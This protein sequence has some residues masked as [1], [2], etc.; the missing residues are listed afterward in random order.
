M[1]GFVTTYAYKS[2]APPVDR[3]ALLSM[4]E[5]MVSR[6][7]DGEGLWVSDDG[8]VGLAHRRLAIID[9]SYEANQPLTI[10]SGRYRIVY[11]GEIYNFRDLRKDLEARGEIFQTH[12]DTEVLLRLYKVY[13]RDMV[14]KLRGMYAFSIWDETKK[15][16]F[17]A[18]DPFGIKP[19]YY[20][21]D[22][23]TF[24]AASQVKALLKGAKLS[25][26][27]DPAGHVGFFLFG[28]VPEPHTLFSDIHAL[29]AGSTL[30]V[31]GE[32]AH[33]ENKF[34]DLGKILSEAQENAEAFAAPNLREALLDSVRHHLVSDVPVGVFLS[35]GLDSG[36]LAGLASEQKK[37]GLDTLTLG[38]DAFRGTSNDEVPLAEE[39]AK[40]YGT[41]HTT[42]RLARE[43]FQGELQNL[44]AAMDQPTI[45][46]VNTYFVSK[47]AAGT[48]LK[49]AISGLGGDELFAGYDSFRQ[50]PALVSR[51]GLVPGMKVLGRGLRVLTA[52]L[53]RHMTSPKYAGLLEYGTRYEDAY[54]LRRSLFMPWELPDVLDADMVREGWEAL[55]PLT[56]LGETMGKIDGARTKVTALEAAWYMKN[57]LL[58]DADWAGMAHSLEIRT[59]L[60]DASLFSALAPAL[61]RADG[62]DKQAMAKTPKSPL[63]KAVLERP[64][65][66]FSVPIRQW[67]REGEK[68]KNAE[69]QTGERGLRGWAK[70]VYGEFV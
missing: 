59:P 6:G 21:D 62:F 24:F 60:V 67:I 25:K 46:G 9:T 31:D 43:N 48:G 63:P 52:P 53:I 44:F 7:P 11:N 56:R 12:S 64:K 2:A 16:V 70:Q 54:L 13:G 34:F 66:G 55:A 26:A 27:Y 8:R 49:V 3:A 29:C 15:G 17:L 5:T 65:T 58:R 20:A 40:V 41:R 14:H 45:D 22:G 35:A 61:V 42:K 18:R 30:W 1:C 51:L 36:T 4:R 69:N 32:G 23:K 37:E 33:E 39:V 19:L 28:Y 47:A 38:F 57:Q 10:S 68:T 50:I